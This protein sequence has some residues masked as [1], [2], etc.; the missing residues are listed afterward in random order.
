MVPGRVFS[1][2]PS[3][4]SQTSSGG[5]LNAVGHLAEN[6]VGYEASYKEPNGT[7]PF[8]KVDVTQHSGSWYSNFLR[9][10]REINKRCRG[11]PL[12]WRFF[13]INY[14]NLLTSHAFLVQ[15][16]IG[17]K[18][19]LNRKAYHEDDNEDSDKEKE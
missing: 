15:N 12:T 18:G 19:F 14:L 8:V 5:V 16:R 2:P 7:W 13:R 17:I 9:H 1:G 10:C 4:C 6:D 11:E 3:K